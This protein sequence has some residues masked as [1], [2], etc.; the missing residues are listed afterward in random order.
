MGLADVLDIMIVAFLIY[1]LIGLVRM[2]SSSKVAKGLV[3]LLL[4]TWVSGQFHMTVVN[5]LLRMTMELGLLA[6]VV[7][8]QPELRRVLEKVGT[9]RFFSREKHIRAMDDA[10]A[11]VVL[12][13][14]ELSDSRTGALLVFERDNR[15]SEQVHTGTVI[16]AAMTAEL[17]KN[18]FYPKAPLHD[19]AAI[20]RDG[21]LCA[22]GCM[23]PLSH[24]TNLSRD[25]GMR[26]RAGIGMSENSDAVVVIVSEETGSISVA[27]DGMLKRHLS[28]DT[29]DRLLRNELFGEV[30]ETEKEIGFLTGLAGRF[31]GNLK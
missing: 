28:T 11:Q 18:I 8:F 2:T 23:L 4:A 31:K 3:I 22:A 17:I 21:R 29:F 20:V 9:A 1:Q 6:L 26:H 27:I 12:A 7:L 5:Y 15:L 13:C 25:L 16:D 14:G 30:E 24:N 10:I 19:G